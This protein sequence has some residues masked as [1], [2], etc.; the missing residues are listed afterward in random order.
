MGDARDDVRRTECGALARRCVGRVNS[1]CEGGRAVSGTRM[2]D[3][4]ASGADL[5][6]RGPIPRQSVGKA[7]SQLAK[8]P[9]QG[10]H[11]S[12][13]VERHGPSSLGNRPCD[14]GRWRKRCTQAV[15]PASNRPPRSRLTV[16]LPRRKLAV[17]VVL[18]VIVR[19]RPRDDCGLPLGRP[20][21]K[22]AWMDRVSGR[23]GALR[24][25]SAP[26]CSL[27]YW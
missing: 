26:P 10:P 17:A 14:V 15:R 4:E 19:E 18:D 20:C 24:R 23:N 6:S 12:E 25:S 8:A 22:K 7:V 27:Q 5:V 3:R 2:S 16:V 11:E 21:L 1:G 9:E 13:S